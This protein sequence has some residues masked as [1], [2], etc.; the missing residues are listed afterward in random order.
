MTWHARS[1]QENGDGISV[2]VA[3]SLVKRNCL[4][5]GP[6]GSGKLSLV[7]GLAALTHSRARKFLFDWEVERHAQEE[8]IDDIT[9]RESEILE[10]KEIWIHRRIECLPDTL[11]EELL[12]RLQAVS[13]ENGHDVTMYGTSRGPIEDRTVGPLAARTFDLSVQVGEL[14]LDLPITIGIYRGLRNTLQRRYGD[15]GQ[16]FE[17][18]LRERL[19]QT[20]PRASLK[21]RIRDIERAYVAAT[22]G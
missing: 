12:L 19:L 18:W 17:E 2:D 4:V 15:C 22:A 21:Q 5:I 10:G 16:D 11:L 20:G 7:L 9:R 14:T 3:K 6:A 1:L 8:L 13:V